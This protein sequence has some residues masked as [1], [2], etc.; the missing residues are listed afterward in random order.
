MKS[1]KLY[2]AGIVF[3]LASVAIVSCEKTFDEKTLQQTDFT[4]STRVQLFLAMV[5]A[6]RNYVYVD[7]NQVTGSAM[8]SGSVFPSAANSFVVNGGLKAFLVRDTLSTSTQVPLSFAENMQV[9]KNYTVF[10]YDTINTPKQ[11]TVVT[12]IEVPTDTTARVR[13]ANFVFSKTDVP[14]VDI[15]SKRRNVNVFTN[16]PVTDVTGFI[17]FPSAF[18]DTIYVRETGTSNLLATMNSFNPS[19][20]R[21]Y[22]LVFRGRYQSTSGTVVRTLSSFTNW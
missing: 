13:F 11:K 8:S 14:A 9:G 4:N 12:N 3:I 15:F 10:V 20:K 2:I 18:N 19:A 17:P 22:T 7:A 6:T 21:S 5:N 1:I 16:V